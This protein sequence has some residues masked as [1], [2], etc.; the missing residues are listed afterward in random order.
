MFSIAGLIASKHLP[1]ISQTSRMNGRWVVI[2]GFAALFS[3]FDPLEKSPPFRHRR[4]APVSRR[5]MPF[6]A[7][8]VRARLA[9]ERQKRFIGGL[10]ALDAMLLLLFGPILRWI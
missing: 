6:F 8:R 3:G 4:R 10:F 9:R 5:C 1:R 7:V 2:L